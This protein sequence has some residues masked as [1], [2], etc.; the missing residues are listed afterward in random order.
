MREQKASAISLSTAGV[1]S[2]PRHDIR[3]RAVDYDLGLRIGIIIRRAR[4]LQDLTQKELAKK[5][6]ISQAE[7]SQIEKGGRLRLKTLQQVTRGLGQS[8]GEMIT[9]AE[10]FG[11][12]GTELARARTFVSRLQKQVASQQKAELA[13]SSR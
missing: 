10:S 8:L 3:H 12:A 7:I 13:K 5:A 1:K 2:S 9:Y 6:G 4:R 11:D